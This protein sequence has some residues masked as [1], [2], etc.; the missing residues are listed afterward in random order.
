MANEYTVKVTI[1]DAVVE[2]HGDRE[3]IV[4]IVRSLADTLSSRGVRSLP[5]LNPGPVPADTSPPTDKP[6]PAPTGEGRGRPTRVVDPRSFFD[7]KKP[8]S[9]IEAVVAAG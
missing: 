2:V 4:E 3:G 7:A 1:G 5:A 8:S 6:E 9:Q